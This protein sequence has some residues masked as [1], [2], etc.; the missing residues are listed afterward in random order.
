MDLDTLITELQKIRNQYGNVAVG[1]TNPSGSM[2]AQLIHPEFSI[3]SVMFE[4]MVI[5][6]PGEGDK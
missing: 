4:G 6:V 1:I 5:L 3:E 2:M